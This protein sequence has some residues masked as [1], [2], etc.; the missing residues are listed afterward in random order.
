M[1]DAGS[2][3]DCRLNVINW[4]LGR[5]L[6]PIMRRWMRSD[7]IPEQVVFPP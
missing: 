3:L 6:G 5:Q 2:A 1:T 4:V 7:G